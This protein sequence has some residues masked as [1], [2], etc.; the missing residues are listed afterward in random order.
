MTPE[1]RYE[2][3]LLHAD[4]PV[5]AQLEANMTSNDAV[6]SD[7]QPADTGA[8]ADTDAQPADN[9]ERDA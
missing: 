5:R 4:P 3:W 6:T 2:Y 1:K 8:V 9:D 7:A